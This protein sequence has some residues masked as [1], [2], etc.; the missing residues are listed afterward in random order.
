MGNLKA[1]IKAT[2]LRKDIRPLPFSPSKNSL[3]RDRT[4]IVSTQTQPGYDASDELSDHNVHGGS[5]SLSQELAIR[6]S[7]PLNN[8]KPPTPT[9]TS[10]PNNASA[11]VN[12]DRPP[13]ESSESRQQV[14]RTSSSAPILAQARKFDDFSCLANAAEAASPGPK[15]AH[16]ETSAQTRAKMLPQAAAA[17]GTGT[18]TGTLA[19]LAHS[20]SKP[21][22]TTATSNSNS[23]SAAVLGNDLHN[24]D[25]DNP[26]PDSQATTTNAT[27]S[28]TTATA[29]TLV[30]ESATPTTTTTPASVVPLSSPT[31]ATATIITATTTTSALPSIHEHSATPPAGATVAA[32]SPEP[33][34]ALNVQQQHV[35]DDID[36]LNNHH[37]PHS[38]SL[39]TPLSAGR[40]PVSP[41]F[42]SR[43]IGQPRKQSILPAHQTN[44]AKALLTAHISDVELDAAYYDDPDQ[45]IL[46]SSMVTRKIWVKRPMA[47]ATLVT[48]NEDDLVDDVRE[49]ILRKYAN[50]LGRQFDAP[51]LSLRIC[52]REQQNS[53]QLQPDEVI[54]KVIDE[55]YANGQT[56]DDALLIDIPSRRTPKA[57]PNP[58]FYAEDR[59]QE[60]GTDYFPPFSPPAHTHTATLANGQHAFHFAPSMSILTGSHLPAMPSPG[61]TRRL[62]LTNRPKT[63]R[64][65]TASPASTVANS[66]TSQ[67]GA[68]SAGTHSFSRQVRSRT[69]SAASSEQSNHQVVPPI[70]T[71]PAAE[72]TATPPPRVSSPQLSFR[73]KKNKRVEPPSFQAGLLDTAV[74]PINILIV[75]DN[76]INLRLLE[77][78]V[79]RLKVRWQTAVNGREAVD[80]WRAGGFHL[81]L[82][83]IQLPIMNGLE[84]TREIRR[85]E[86][87]NSIGVF[88]SSA[89]SAPDEVLPDPAEQDKLANTEMFKSPVII[90]ALTASSLQS[91]R[92]E[93]L[94]AGCNDF[95]T[96]VRPSFTLASFF[97]YS[98][99]SHYAN[100]VWTACQF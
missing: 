79:K 33:R 75:E 95:L 50:S 29:P 36:P 89:S 78:F 69:H 56:V 19:E 13:S 63:Q 54:C 17:A 70:P 76:M 98:V 77:A 86:R 94:A 14:H 59:P 37:R 5:R 44:F 39:L 6:K 30:I 58:R 24:L 45:H 68:P 47:S 88:S 12:T 7:S 15:Q 20:H 64:M 11:S 96:K 16:G 60:S 83:D 2:F 51:D 99:M 81:V 52:N 80:K 87:V 66:H 22:T 42:L 91:D 74:P 41:S 32:T 85:I 31:A 65:H 23:A 84:A 9:L 92:H 67:A 49:M 4:S 10:S 55:L 1:R 26:R 3:G 46:L 93:A 40:T 100:C 82:M 48:V 35:R 97:A 34:A 61:S 21:A 8:S 73:A 38:P 43:P 72:R 28:T 62:A 57:S 25:V 27:T 90:V 53:R 71:P 18:R